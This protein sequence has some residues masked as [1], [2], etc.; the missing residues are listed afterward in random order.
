[1]LPYSVVAVGVM[2]REG[3]TDALLLLPYRVG[4]L[5]VTTQTEV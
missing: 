4:A 5:A 1:M 3:F 2:R